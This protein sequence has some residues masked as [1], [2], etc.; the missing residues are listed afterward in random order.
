MF[1]NL[2]AEQLPPFRVRRATY[3][4]VEC[5]SNIRLGSVGDAY[6]CLVCWYVTR[7]G[8]GLRGIRLRRL[9]LLRLVRR[10]GDAEL[11]LG[12]DS[13]L[14]SR[15]GLGFGS[16]RGRSIVQLLLQVL[17]FSLCRAIRSLLLGLDILELRLILRFR[18]MLSLMLRLVDISLG[19]S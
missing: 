17:C 11:G 5:I 13:L 7:I 16:L 4:T 3:Y 18:Y 2:L 10:A 14:L 15:L 1:L 12:L 19:L 9:G 6:P 8:F